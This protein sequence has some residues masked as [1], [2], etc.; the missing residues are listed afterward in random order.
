[1]ALC[2]FSWGPIAWVVP[3]EMLP[4]NIRA[5][6]VALGTVANWVAD[7]LVV[8]TYLSLSTALG[9]E[10]AFLV[11]GGINAAAVAFIWFYVPETKGLHL[12]DVSQAMTEQ[13]HAD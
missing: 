3:S 11:Y 8:S 1:V 12:E 9:D 4:T 5:K 6:A 7:Y 10:G 13:D 2:S